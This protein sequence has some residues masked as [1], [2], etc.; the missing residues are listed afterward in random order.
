M[1]YKTKEWRNSMRV[2]VDYNNMMS[3]FL[4]EQGIRDAQLREVK[5]QAEAA[6]RYVAENR[7][8]DELYMGWTELPYNQD[9][10]VADILATAKEVRKKFKYFVVLGIGGS[11]LGPDRKSVV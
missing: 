11:A 8:K 6:Y 4:G 1:G 2:T 7:G 3:K 5:G 9:A 10:I